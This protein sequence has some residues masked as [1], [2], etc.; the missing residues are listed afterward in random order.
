M[1]PTFSG[2]IPF[3]VYICGIAEQNM[4]SVAGGL[5]RK[6]YTFGPHLCGFYIQKGL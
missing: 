3:K 5:A 4:M 2:Y 1:K 6:V